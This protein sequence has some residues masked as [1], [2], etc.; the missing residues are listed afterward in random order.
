MESQIGSSAG[1]QAVLKPTEEYRLEIR[2]EGGKINCKI[3]E[4]KQNNI[5]QTWDDFT[6]NTTIHGIKYIF[7]KSHFKFRRYLTLSPCST[8][9]L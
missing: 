6:Q 9:G 5:T 2:D 7:E 1:E 4:I 8:F 3:Q